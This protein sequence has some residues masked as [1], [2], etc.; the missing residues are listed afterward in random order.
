MSL[1]TQIFLLETN[2]KWIIVDVLLTKLATIESLNIDNSK[3]GN[4]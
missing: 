4:D 2:M 3:T 1:F